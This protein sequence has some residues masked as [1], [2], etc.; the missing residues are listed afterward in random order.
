MLL[1]IRGL[2]GR[3][4]GNLL[5]DGERAQGTLVRVEGVQESGWDTEGS[6]R[7]SPEYLFYL[8]GNRL[9]CGRVGAAGVGRSIVTAGR[10][11]F[12]EH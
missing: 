10:T 11:A 7:G 5:S 6:A 8:T 3:A 1:R 2:Q 9:A 12:W 4:V